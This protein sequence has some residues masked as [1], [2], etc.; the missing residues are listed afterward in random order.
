MEKKQSKQVKKD[1]SID[2]KAGS[3]AYNRFEMQISQTLHMAIE[4]YYDLNYLFVLDHYDDITLFDNDMSPESV[5]YY[6]M[7]TSE[8]CISIDTAISQDWIAKLYEQLNNPAWIV[9]EL[10]LITNCPLKVTV[11]FNDD[12]GNKHTEEKK[13]TAE[14]TSFLE[15]NQLMIDRLK[16]DIATRKGIAA[17]EVDLTKFVHMRTTLSIPKHREIVEQEMSD[18]LLSQYPRI[19][20]ES[21]KTIFGAMIDLLSR[22]QAYEALDKNA[23]FADVRQKK[24]VSK[25]DFSRIIEE[26]MYISVPT[27][28]EIDQ[29]M[30]YSEDE[31]MKAALE[32]TKVLPDVQGKSESFAALYRQVRNICHSNPINDEE[33]VKTYCERIYGTLPSKNPIYN[34]SYVGVLIASIMI[35]EWRRSV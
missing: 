7:K 4:L 10:G 23:S 31:K 30:G 6:Q 16:E 17:E 3:R 20:I 15:F 26:S 9:K 25:S 21:A 33:P 12:D 32:Y 35:N 1:V 34:K 14:R 27:F 19:T 22:R 11:K 2:T 13:Y 18:F 5:S 28:Q 29:W 24:G 8:D